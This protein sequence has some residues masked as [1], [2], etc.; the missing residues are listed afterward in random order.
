MA[1]HAQ[2]HVHPGQSPTKAIRSRQRYDCASNS[3][4]GLHCISSSC[5]PEKEGHCQGKQRYNGSQQ[6]CSQRRTRRLTKP[7]PWSIGKDASPI[8]EKATNSAY[9]PCKIEFFEERQA[10]SHSSLVNRKLAHHL[11]DHL[12]AI[13]QHQ[14]GNWPQRCHH[15]NIHVRWRR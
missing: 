10:T 13:R 9:N 15:K 4:D 3:A 12:G 5:I 11:V 2:N 1:V 14:L 8:F 6:R 7:R